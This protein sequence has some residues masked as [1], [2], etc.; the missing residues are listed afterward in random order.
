[1]SKNEW[2]MFTQ[3]ICHV[4]V[5]NP[6]IRCRFHE[7]F[8]KSQGDTSSLAYS[9]AMNIFTPQSN[10]VEFLWLWNTINYWICLKKCFSNFLL[11]TEPPNIVWC[12]ISCWWSQTSNYRDCTLLYFLTT[13]GIH[14]KM[15]S[16]I[17]WIWTES[18]GTFLTVLFVCSFLVT[19]WGASPLILGKLSV[20][21]HYLLSNEQIHWL[22]VTLIKT[23]YNLEIIQITG[24]CSCSLA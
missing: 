24:Y 23:Q 1:M 22:T 11:E 16:T 8:Q 3:P 4:Q 2:F 13:S 18:R 7:L 15:S 19:I 10:R 17:I 20:S 9:K 5:Y 6:R 12:I 14:L 21:F